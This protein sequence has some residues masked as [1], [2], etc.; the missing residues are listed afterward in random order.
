MLI[1]SGDQATE[2][3]VATGAEQAVLVARLQADS[4]AYQA[5]V[6][7]YRGMFWLQFALLAARCSSTSIVARSCRCSRGRTGVSWRR[8]SSA[9]A[10]WVRCRVT[11]ARE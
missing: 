4:Q 9:H 7:L 3:A 10:A 6:S 5:R 8:T 1:G 2:F 11:T